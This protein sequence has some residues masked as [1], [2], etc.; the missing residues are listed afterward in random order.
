[1][2]HLAKKIRLPLQ[3]QVRNKESLEC[4]SKRSLSSGHGNRE[5]LCKCLF[6]LHNFV[7]QEH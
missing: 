3:M 1:M 6:C 5:S 7:A 2:L 4:S